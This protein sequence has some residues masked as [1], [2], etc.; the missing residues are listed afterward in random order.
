MAP[1]RGPSGQ[2][3]LLAWTSDTTQACYKFLVGGFKYFVFT[4]IWGRSPFWLIFFRWVET[5]NWLGIEMLFPSWFKPW[6]LCPPYSW[7]SL[8]TTFEFGSCEHCEL[9][10]P[11]KGHNGRIVWSKLSSSVP[12]RSWTCPYHHH[13]HHHR[14]HHHHHH[15]HHHHG[16]MKWL[17]FLLPCDIGGAMNGA[18][19]DIFSH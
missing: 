9:H 6:P 12:S 4:P 11:W 13:H 5:T 3:L 15:R 19:Y 18:R 14:H 2:D 1:A 7:R 10:H 17:W 8:H 16:F